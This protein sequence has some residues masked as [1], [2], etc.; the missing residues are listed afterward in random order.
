[1]KKA[2]LVLAAVFAL[3]LGSCASEPA[4]APRAGVPPEVS[5]WNEEHSGDTFSGMGIST[6]DNESDALQQATVL[7]RQNLAASLETEV[8]AISENYVQRSEANGETDRVAKFK[9]ATKQLV[10]QTVSRSK[11]YGPYMNDRGSTY[12]VVYLDKQS[13]QKDLNTYVDEIFSA[14]ESELNNML[15]VN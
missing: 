14:T 12:I 15:G 8:A 7:A 6:F 1:M 4:P 2:V 3:V 5:K 9:D 11:T 13:T 10:N